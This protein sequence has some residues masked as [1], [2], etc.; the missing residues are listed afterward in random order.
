MRKR[1]LKGQALITAGSG[2]LVRALGF[3]LR[4][5]LSR[6]LGAEALG[7]MELASG[8]HQLALTPAAA[9]LPGAMSHL[10]ARAGDERSR[11]LALMAGRR[12]ALFTG[13]V[14]SPLF[15]LLS[16]EIAR[17]LGDERT[18][19]SLLLFS[20]CALLV[21]LS[22]AYDGWF[23]GQG[24]AL[25][26]ALSEGAEQLV[27][28]FAVL[29][30]SFLLPR[31]TA[32]W[33]AALPALASTLGEAAGLAVVLALAGRMGR[34]GSASP[35]ARHKASP[36]PAAGRWMPPGGE[37]SR[38]KNGGERAAA[39]ALQRRMV[40]LALPLMLNRGCHAGL[41]AISS[42]IL[43]LRLMAGGLDRAEALSRLG[44][45]QGMVLPM[46][47]LPGLFSGA[48]AAVG[49]PAMA[50]CRTHRA[51]NRLAGRMLGASLSIGLLC[52]G[53]LYALSPWIARRIYRLPELSPLLRSACPLA[54]VLPVQ[55]AAGGMMTGL[56]MQ[57]KTL[58]SSLLGAGAT[59]L[60]TWRWA[61][62]P[63]RGIYGAAYASL[64]G[65]G[66]TLFCCLAQLFCRETKEKKS[67][68][69]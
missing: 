26:P 60:C 33:R 11:R 67:G 32:A 6:R 62:W 58:L 38:R 41:R 68:A 7:I 12:L 4:L 46:T 48:I 69:A 53:G 19:P 55:Q 29:G 43:P 34:D 56:G 25:P 44:M 30:L 3:G 20:P 42:V 54:V 9:G 65:H 28:I 52:A 1:S 40:R 21:G 23:F 16:P 47:L 66:L 10:T 37:A 14:I 39:R 13:A 64:A 35:G 22:S 59:L 8:A 63:G 15:L 5:W 51:E 49:G 45:L 27:R 31:A 24:R 50:R 61:A 57:K 2:A 36:P 17:L 18:L